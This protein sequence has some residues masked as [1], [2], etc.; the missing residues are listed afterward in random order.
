MQKKQG[1]NTKQGE[2]NKRGSERNTEMQNKTER[3]VTWVLKED[4]ISPP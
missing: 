2:F 3:K 1:K 4:F